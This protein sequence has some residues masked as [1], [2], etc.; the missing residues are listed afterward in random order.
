[1][2]I[3]KKITVADAYRVGDAVR[4]ARLG[5]GEVVAAG[6]G[7]VVVRFEE[8][9][10]TL[11]LEAAPLTKVGHDD[12]QNEKVT[13]GRNNRKR[14]KGYAPWR[15]Q[16]KTRIILE[17]VDEI[18][19]EYRAYLPLTVRQIFY[20]LVGRFDYPKTEQAYERVG[21]YLVR[22]RRARLIP[23]DHIR[24][25]SAS[26]MDHLHFDGEEDFYRYVNQLGREY[27]QDKLAGQKVSIRLHCEA[28]G[29]MP[30]IYSAL[31]PYSV[32]V[33]SCS[34]FDSLTARRQLA[35]WF[36]DTYVYFG[37]V[38]VMLHLGDYDP[39]GESIF[40][41]LIEDVVGFLEIDAP[42][43]LR[44]YD[45]SLLFKRVALTEWQ[46]RRYDLPTAPPKETSSRTKNWTGNATCQLEALPPNTLRRIV[47]DTVEGYIDAEALEEAREKEVTARRN[48]AGALP[49]VR[50]EGGS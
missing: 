35:K 13:A 32:P 14:P 7:K 44:A 45:R 17:Q 33:Y 26:V 29:M 19:C 40:D 5:L 24:D 50:S 8:G 48:I 46:V 2:T 43:L 49:P 25:D 22:A 31:E 12:A 38:P 11:L 36:H 42:H 16:T 28:E 39:D 47:V 37:K 6:D 27:K 21:N 3:E 23:F 20:R 15:P 18:L 10:K 34:G 4:H 30:Q 41:S 9:E 1:M